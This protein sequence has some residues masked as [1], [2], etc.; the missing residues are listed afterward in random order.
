MIKCDGNKKQPSSLLPKAYRDDCYL[1]NSGHSASGIST[2]A[3]NSSTAFVIRRF[4]NI[5]IK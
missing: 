5:K 4:I 2:Q 3:V 1:I